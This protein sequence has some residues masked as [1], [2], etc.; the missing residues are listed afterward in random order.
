MAS[1]TPLGPWHRS[2]KRLPH[3]RCGRVALRF[4]SSQ[5][6]IMCSLATL[7]RRASW[8]GRCWRRGQRRAPRRR[9][10][11]PVGLLRPCAGARCGRRLACLSRRTAGP[12]GAVEVVVAAV[13]RPGNRLAPLSAAVGMAGATELV[14]NRLAPLG[15]TTSAAGSA[16]GTAGL[17]GEPGAAR[18]SCAALGS[19][20]RRRLELAAA[21]RA[22]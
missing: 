22:P 21:C 18:C 6:P 20:R 2:Q 16:A 10:L 9:R 19:G 7:P 1:A 3:P 8:M 17:F 11:L 12:A 15:G 14:G 13:D 4:E 5:G